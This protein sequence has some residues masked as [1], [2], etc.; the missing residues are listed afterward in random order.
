MEGSLATSKNIFIQLQQRNYEAFSRTIVSC[1]SFS[2]FKANLRG[3]LSVPGNSDFKIFY[4][5]DEDDLISM[6]S[7]EE[8]K[9]AI[10][11]LNNT[12]LRVVVHVKDETSVQSASKRKSCQRSSTGHCRKQVKLDRKLNARRVKSANVPKFAPGATVPQTWQVR[13][14]G[15]DWEEGVCLIAGKKNKFGGPAV[16]PID[17]KVASGTQISIT[18]NLIAPTEAGVHKGFW[19]LCTSDGKKFGPRFPVQVE[20]VDTDSLPLLLPCG[21]ENDGM[22]EDYDVIGHLEKISLEKAYDNERWNPYEN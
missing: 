10:H 13:N 20:V 2:V 12:E 6:T 4:L 22:G 17:G 8:L 19:Q 16:I 1:Y 5:D 14:S 15:E 11:L 9:H 7:D 3:L 21:D 18:A